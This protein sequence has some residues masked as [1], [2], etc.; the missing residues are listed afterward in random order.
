VVAAN[1]NAYDWHRT[2]FFFDDL[3][4]RYPIELAIAVVAATSLLG[5]LRKGARA[6]SPSAINWIR[7]VLGVY[8]VT[9]FLVSLTI[10]KVASEVNYLIEFMGVVCI[11]VGIALAEGFAGGRLPAASPS[12]ASSLSAV[13]LP[14]LL[15]IPMSGLLRRPA[16]EWVEIPSVHEQQEMAQLVEIIRNADGPVLSQNLTL[17]FLAGKP[18]EFQPCDLA[19]MA[20]QGEWNQSGFVAR[21][22][23][24]QYQLV[25]LHIDVT[26]QSDWEGF[27]PS[28]LAAIRGHYVAAQSLAGYWIY[29]PQPPS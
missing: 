11:C 18:V 15:L 20:Y 2:V 16:I 23:G 24:R 21:I 29:K 10:G 9:A 8:L 22:E 26:R 4:K 14:C 27:T 1:Q 28:M 7:P 6:A 25:I 13:F 17:L 19:H 3:R 12:L 5:E